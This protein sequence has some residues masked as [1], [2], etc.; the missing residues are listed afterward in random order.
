MSTYNSF[1]K[2]TG[3]R[4]S[5]K[6]HPNDQESPFACQACRKEDSPV[7]SPDPESKLTIFNY[8]FVSP[9][10]WGFYRDCEKPDRLV[11][12]PSTG[13]SL[14]SRPDGNSL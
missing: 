8:P 4:K 11:T 6:T 13:K 2:E 12:N 1:A 14:E 5:G 3:E 9:I 10:S 7:F